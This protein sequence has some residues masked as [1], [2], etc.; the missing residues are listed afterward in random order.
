M[1]NKMISM[2]CADKKIH[3]SSRRPVKIACLGA[4]HPAD[5]R[6][7]RRCGDKTSSVNADKTILELCR[8]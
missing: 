1:L 3:L 8:D 7:D 6:E 4:C 5:E 2:L